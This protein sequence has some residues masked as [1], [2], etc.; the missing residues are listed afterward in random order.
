VIT[1]AIQKL[2]EREDLTAD[3]ARFAMEDL[4]SGQASEAQIAGF[5]TALRMKGETPTE[6]IAFA[7]VMRE[8]ADPFWNENV[9][10]VVDTCGTGGDHSGT[11][12]I[13]TATAL[14]VGTTEVTEVSVAKHGNRSATSQCG[15]A[16]VL[17]ALGL[18]IRMSIEKLRRAITDVGFAFLFAQNFHKSMHHVMRTR[19]QL[20]VRTIFN[21]LG[22]LANPAHPDF[23]VL[24]V[25]SRK[26]MNIVAEALVGLK[27]K[28]AFVVHSEDGLDE[29][30]ISARTHLIEIRNNELHRSVIS[31]EDF[32][33]SVASAETLRGGDAHTN[34][35]IIESILQGEK[36]ARREVVLMNAAAALLVAGSAQSF[37]DGFKKAAEAIDTGEAWKTLLKLRELSK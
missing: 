10:S 4:M 16:D 17:E 24:G 30:S 31:P 22:P 12:N 35:K 29:I 14:V 13:S 11:F 15:S 25:S 36:G 34:A 2:V 8:K 23:Q 21:L 7:S 5:L 26:V 1:D 20:K 33:A 18:D 27:V 9:V 32:G 19:T 37:K 28:R 6:L 3:E